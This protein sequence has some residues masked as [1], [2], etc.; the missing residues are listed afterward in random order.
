M[1]LA[2][3][4]RVGSYEILGHLGSGGMGDVYRARD[5]KLN[6]DVAIKGIPQ[7]FALDPDRLARFTREAQVLAALN[8]PNICQLY[9]VGP[10]WLVM[11]LVE[12]KPVAPVDNPRKVLDLA[13]QIAD[14]LAAAH[15][16]GIV[17]RD[18]KPDNVL[19]TREGRIKILDFGV[20][21]L[22]RTSADVDALSTMMATDVGTITG[23]AAYM[24]PEQARGQ[25]LDARSDQFSFGL[26]LYEMVTGQKTFQRASAA[27]TMTAIIREEAAPVPADVFTPLRWVIERCL[28]K[29]PVERYDSTNDL[30][31]ELRRLREHVS[32]NNSTK[33][34]TVHPRSVALPTVGVGLVALIVGFGVAAFWP[35]PPSEPAQT[36]PFATEFEL[37]AMPR[38]SPQGDRIAYV[39]PV[40]GILQVFTKSLDSTTPTQI[41]HETQPAWN[42][43][44]SANATRIYFITG[45]RP[46]TVLRSI[47]VAGGSSEVVLDRVSKA[48]LSPDGRTLAVVVPDAEGAY[49][50]AFSS[51]P[52][53]TPRFDS[54]IPL[55][56]GALLELR[57]DLTGTYLGVSNNDRFWK[58]PLDGGPSEEVERRPRAP[59]TWRFAW[60]ADGPIV[61]DGAVAARAS[62][63]WSSPV[64]SGRSRTI[65]SGPS[66]DAYPAL[67]PDGRTL[68]YASG[69]IG[70]DLIEIPLDGAR[71]TDV[72]ATSR[73]ETAPAWAPDGIR[74]AYVT[75]RGGVQEIWL[76]NRLD[77]SER[78]VASERQFDQVDW[79]FDCVVSPDGT[80][81]AF[82]TLQESKIAV[83]ISTLS[84]DTPVPLWDDPQRSPQRG[85]SWSPDGNWI[86][87]YG[88]HNGRAAILKA[89]VG[90]DAAAEFVAYMARGFPPR[91]SPRGDWI[92]FR[93]GDRL[94]IVSPDG[95]QDRIISQ[96][97]W[98]TYGWSKDG[99]GVYG[100]SY[101]EKRRL[102]LGRV[103][104]ETLK[105]TEIADL[106]P[107]PPAFDLVDSLNDFAYRGFSLHPDGES[108][109]TSVL[110]IRTQIYLMKDFDRSVRLVDNWF[111]R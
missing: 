111:R 40:D 64:A 38:W 19:V 34:A 35:T 10:D 65:T 22:T 94:R 77:G 20:A 76:R 42:P 39:A 98:E 4:S 99:A 91:R 61:G 60:S 75:N 66:Q 48:D 8:H 74:F 56:D 88:I 50:L 73:V 97:V 95:K 93:D 96:R 45:I 83:W 13:I 109:L 89:R 106:G 9:D 57:F 53:A 27:E 29:D 87:Y 26:I 71:P 110:R 7:Q 33:P 49:Q 84:G 23:T 102:M 100:I 37:Q 30:Y 3:N 2:V 70:F 55:S 44:W 54:R 78:L 25:P 31:R 58:I 47:A 5:T 86:V 82:R 24:S 32:E 85:P 104:V 68:A 41:T 72:I 16:A 6:R 11:E 105:E 90:A 80:R 62:H 108:F 18:L 43:L 81:V 12:G 46:K 28:E 69:E 1:P 52:G 59:F 92:V 36:A 17:H 101:T 79:F 107:I 103:D 67:A 15:A 51:P 14:G 21:K 63:L